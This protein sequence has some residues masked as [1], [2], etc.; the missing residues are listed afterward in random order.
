MLIPL[1]NYILLSFKEKIKLHF[2]PFTKAMGLNYT[3]FA[4]KQTD[5]ESNTERLCTQRVP[6]FGH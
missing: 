1:E 4:C 3:H 5:I 2:Q 6:K